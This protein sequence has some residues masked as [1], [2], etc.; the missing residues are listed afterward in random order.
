[1]GILTS[2]L[3][4]SLLIFFHELGHF[5]A[6]KYFGVKVEVF[7]I[8]FGKKIFTKRV[9]ETEYAISAIPLGGYVKMLGQDDANPTARINETN[10]YTV[11]KPWQKLIILSAGAFAN[12]VL[13]FILYVFIA[14]LGPQ[15]LA[16]IVGEV[17]ADFPAQKAGIKQGDTLVRVNSYE[18]REWSDISKAIDASNDPLEIEIVRDGKNIV[19]TIH[20]QVADTQ[21]LFREDIKKRMIGIS[22]APELITLE[23]TFLEA[24]V[25][26]TDKTAESSTLI[27][28]SVQKLLDG[29]V[30]ASEVGGV[31]SI[32]QF[33][34]EASSIGIIAL[35]SLT[36]LIS[37]N[38]GVL[39]LLPIP[40]LDGGHIIFTLYEAIMKK[41]PDQE[42][43]YK[44]TVGGWVLL[45]SLMFLGLYND[46][47]R[48]F[49]GGTG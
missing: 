36:A 39:N 12:F 30:P 3:V 7:S 21:N 43:L 18:I 5:L 17:K 13:A 45:F 11:K 20:T 19:Y 27:V 31:L 35:F 44:L 38:L 49:L 25:Y 22:P 15:A 33:T 42:V 26:G 24:L 14:L 8:G 40:A 9:G 16:P 2:L 47:H 48:I 32:V 41:A 46:I 6:A 28:K 23:Y 1:M 4:L 37:V 10:S 34:A 29:T